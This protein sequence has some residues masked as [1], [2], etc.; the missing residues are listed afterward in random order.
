VKITSL[1]FAIAL[2]LGTLLPVVDAPSAQEKRVAPPRPE[3]LIGVWIGF[4]E[5]EEFTR[6]DLRA[7][8]TGYCAYVAPPDFITHQY[9]VH[10]YRVTAW[11]IDGWKLNISLAP[12]DS[13]RDESIYLKGR[14]GYLSLQ[15]EIGGANRKWKE[16]VVLHKESR[17]QVSNLETKTKIEEVE[18]K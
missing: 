1:V 13:R 4:W 16:Q 14:A 7:D 11:S 6:L 2:L 17:I 12:V 5:D 18:K 9:G 10:V 8:S 3:D 15:L